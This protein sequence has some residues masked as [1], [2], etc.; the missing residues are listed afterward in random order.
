MDNHQPI[1]SDKL[2][3]DRRGYQFPIFKDSLDYVKILNSKRLHLGEFVNLLNENGVN[4]LLLDFTI[5]DAIETEKIC[6]IFVNNHQE[7]KLEEV[8]YGH[9]KEGIL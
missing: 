9:F 6:E 4:N 7:I 8:T 1:S 3:V 2:L 5:E